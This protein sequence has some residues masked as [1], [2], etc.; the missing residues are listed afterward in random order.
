MKY[1]HL[2]RFKKLQEDLLLN[3][4]SQLPKLPV[5]P[6]AQTLRKYEKTLQPLLN[7]DEEKQRVYEIIEK[8]GNP[9]GLGAKLQL[10]LEDR[11]EKMDNWAYKYWL[12]DM[13]LGNQA[14]LP[15]NSNP[16]MVLPSRRFTT[17][18]DL[19]RFT[20]RLIQAIM[21]YKVTLDQGLLETEKAT[22][23]EPG[24]PL[25]MAQYYR[26]L[27]SCR[28]PGN[29]IDQ[30]YISNP[31]KNEQQHV[32]VLCRNQFYCIP[33]QA[34]DRGRLNEDE[35]CSQLLYILDD[36]PCLKETCPIGLLTGWK[37]NLWAEVREIL[38]QDQQNSRNLEMIEKSLFLIC[39]DEP[40]PPNFNST[41]MKKRNSN[42]E[43]LKR[44][45]TNLTLQMLHGGGSTFNTA[46][47]W[48]DKTLQII[49]SGDGSLGLC[50]EHS[51]AEAVSLIQ[52]IEKSIGIVNDLPHNPE[53]PKSN[54]YL[55]N[56]EKLTWNVEQDV[57]VKIE[58]ATRF[59]DSLI[60]DLDFYVYKFNNYGKNL[61]KSFKVSPDA[62][63]QLALQLAYYKIY[64]KLTATYESA[65]TRRFL[66]GRVDCIRSATPEALKWVQAMAQQPS[67]Y[68]DITNKK[69]SFDLISEEQKLMLFRDA[70]KA[71]TEEMIDN[72]LGQGID[73]HLLGLREAAKETSPVYSSP[74]PE[75]FTDQSYQLANKFLLSTSQ[76]A[77][78]LENSFMGYGAVEPDGY[79]ASYNPKNDFIIFCISSFHSSDKTDTEKFVFSL[80]ESLI[81]MQNLLA[82]K[83]EN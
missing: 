61:I 35:L 52:M 10:Y 48:F 6:L 30:Q 37:R 69:V 24:Q 43:E 32:I 12:K 64:S 9:N 45:E 26:I 23:R 59:I 18:L 28:I 83:R 19:A 31:L 21:D 4:V 13:Y 44:D 53:M 74:L 67:K 27:G 8:F 51:F 68:D 79:G 46:N 39:L 54:S 34:T 49:V 7:D 40:L 47:R 56:P 11:K 72:I 70:I 20:S 41:I 25:C 5:P 57:H 1:S 81:S 77:T 65:S 82:T 17:I 2:K 75:I 60:K 62:Y 63:I 78:S 71:Q 58:E 29:Q 80:E 16:G 14:S 15:I 76:V 66:N 22:S 38:K 55:P 36:A 73:V 33:I 42:V 3:L 50:Y